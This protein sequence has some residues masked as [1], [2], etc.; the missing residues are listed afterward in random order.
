[1]QITFIHLFIALFSCC[2]PERQWSES[3]RKAALEKVEIPWN[4]GQK[5]YTDSLGNI[6]NI[7]YREY[8]LNDDGKTELLLETSGSYYL[9]GSSECACFIL[10]QQGEILLEFIGGELSV[11]N[12][13]TDGYKD[14]QIQGKKASVGYQWMTNKYVLNEIGWTLTSISISV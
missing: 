1:M 4:E 13:K 8:D 14:L 12:S 7:Q 2:H 11:L 3:M 10:N 9:W 6:I 5:M